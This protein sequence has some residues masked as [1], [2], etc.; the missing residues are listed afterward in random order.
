MPTCRGGAAHHELRSLPQ[1][2]F[3]S[4][5]C[6][7]ELLRAVLRGKPL[8]ALLEPEA[9]HGAQS[10]EEIRASLTD[11][12]VHS[13]GLEDEMAELGYD[14]MPGGK[15][16]FD[17]L[18]GSSPIEWNRAARRLQHT[19]KSER[20]CSRATHRELLSVGC[21]SRLRLPS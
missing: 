11:E 5:A 8:V 12:W 21:V 15:A 1:R 16:V 4:K 9:R 14:E 7:R 13:W 19:H 17:A 20:G 3:Q 2:Y 10:I 18:F 6:A